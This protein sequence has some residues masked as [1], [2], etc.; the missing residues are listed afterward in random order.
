MVAGVW[1]RVAILSIVCNVLAVLIGIG[2][3]V[4]I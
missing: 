4:L 3:G 2:I 1:K